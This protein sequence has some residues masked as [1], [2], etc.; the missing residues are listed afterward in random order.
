MLCGLHGG[1]D[2]VHAAGSCLRNRLR[3]CTRFQG[4]NC[5]EQPQCTHHL[6]GDGWSTSVETAGLH[7]VHHGHDWGRVVLSLM[8]LS[9]IGPHDRDASDVAGEEA[10]CPSNEL[11]DNLRRI[12]PM[13]GGE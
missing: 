5:L 10:V 3:F 12:L 13:E 11:E 6:V 4:S 9:S 8:R 1:E 2:V 7:R